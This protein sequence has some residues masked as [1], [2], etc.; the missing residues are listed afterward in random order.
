MLVKIKLI[1]ISGLIMLLGAC[2]GSGGG[3]KLPV[4][5][6][7]E[8]AL[9]DYMTGLEYLDNIR[10][11]EAREMFEQALEKDPKFAMAHIYSIANGPIDAQAQKHLRKALQL[12]P[13]VSEAE[14]IM[15]K[16]AKAQFDNDSEKG[17][18]LLEKLADM[19]PDDERAQFLY[20]SLL[21]SDNKGGH[22]KAAIKALKKAISI[23]KDFAPA[24]N[25]LGY[26]YKGQGDFDKA[27]KALRKYS[28]LLPEEANPYDSM[29][30]LLVDKGEVE[31]A[32]EYYIK[33]FKINPAFTISQR[34]A[35]MNQVFLGRYDEARENFWSAYEVE[36]SDMVKAAT[37]RQ[38][39]RSYIYEGNP[40]GAAPI[41]EQALELANLSGSELLMG[42]VNW[43]IALMG[44]FKGNLVQA[45]SSMEIAKEIVF[46]SDIVFNSEAFLSEAE[47]AVF[48]LDVLLDVLGG[49]VEVASRKVAEF[50]EEHS[51]DEDDDWKT[52]YAEAKGLVEFTSGAYDA[53]LE[54]FESVEDADALNLFYQAK[55]NLL[56]GNTGRGMQLMKKVATR[57]K[58][59]EDY[60]PFVRGQA[61]AALAEAQ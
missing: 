7:S 52:P 29:G 11:R 57:N 37:L 48:F 17:F 25:M 58:D 45:R 16:A 15:I 21:Y 49:E 8:E 40:E 54:S 34:K 31:E 59:N 18:K 9:A 56:Q 50:K 53:A 14:Q 12:A 61:I 13:Q 19:Y 35:A 55:I 44:L 4:T 20:G 24:Y 60:Y 1:I 43:G 26:L 30:D 38:I 42:Q 27:E 2:G 10:T 33:S 22:A 41:A 23:N 32:L 39:A 51:D 46:A 3:E 47:R 5:T 6:S 28:Q 36:Q